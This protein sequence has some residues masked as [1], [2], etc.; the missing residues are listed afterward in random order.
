MGFN[1]GFKGLRKLLHLIYGALWLWGNV[2]FIS[3]DATYFS[4]ETTHKNIDDVFSD[5]VAS[6]WRA[7]YTRDGTWFGAH[8]SLNVSQQKETPAGHTRQTD[9][10]TN[11]SWMQQNLSHLQLNPLHGQ[12]NTH[13]H[14]IGWWSWSSQY[15]NQSNLLKCRVSSVQPNAQLFN[16]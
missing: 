15:S 9:G 4:L 5:Y 2:T 6:F 12:E 16:P 14:V 1:S 3:H 10:R 11:H 13:T 7:I 8:L